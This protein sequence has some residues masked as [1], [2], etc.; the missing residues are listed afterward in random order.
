MDFYVWKV[1][2]RFGYKKKATDI[3]HKKQKETWNNKMKQNK[4]KQKPKKLKR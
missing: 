2:I 1:F 3:E 4:I